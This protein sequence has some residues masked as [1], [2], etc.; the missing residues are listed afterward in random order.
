MEPVKRITDALAAGAADENA[1]N[2]ATRDAYDDLKALITGR[3][4]EGKASEGELI[5]KNHAE[6][7]AV[8]KEPLKDALIE[9]GADR[10]EEILAAA[11]KLMAARGAVQPAAGGFHVEADKIKGVV[12]AEKIDN[13]TLIIDKDQPVDMPAV[14]QASA[15]GRYLK[16]VISH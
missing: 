15:L 9:S 8:W 5:L 11:E 3:F 6:K 12:Q 10:D 4:P 1:G 7:P 16:H 14:D 13:L 2:S